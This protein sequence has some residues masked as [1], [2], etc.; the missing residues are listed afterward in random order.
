MN[1]TYVILPLFGLLLAYSNKGNQELGTLKK[2]MEMNQQIADK[3]KESV[4]AFFKALEDE[5]MDALVAL[6]D[7]DAKHIN[8]YASGIFPEGADGKDGIRNYWTP[9]FPNFEGMEFPISEIYAMEDPSMVYVKYRGKIKLKNI[10]GF[11]E[12][13]YYSTFKF[14][15]AG[16]IEE[17][18]EIFNPI[19]AARSFGLLDKIK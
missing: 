1:W 3:N 7:D 10:A 2:E 5:N 12:N 18:V 15:D 14:S 11:Y 17:F 6:F 19:I 13:E 16:L 9:V 8:P 4:R